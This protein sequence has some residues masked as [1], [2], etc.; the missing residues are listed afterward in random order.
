MLI[1]R[2][3]DAIVGAVLT[4]SHARGMVGF[5]GGNKA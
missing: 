3:N 1:P 2:L 4:A 5:E